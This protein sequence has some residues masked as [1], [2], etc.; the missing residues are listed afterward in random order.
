MANSGKFGGINIES[1]S[2]HSDNN[3]FSVD[4]QGKFIAQDAEITGKIVSDEGTIGGIIIE[5]NSIRTSNDLF[6]LTEEGLLTAQ[7]ADITGKITSDEGLIGGV[8]ISENSIHSANDKFIVTDAGALTAT[9]ADITGKITANEG[10]IGGNTIAANGITGLK[11]SIID[12]VIEAEDATITG[13]TR[14]ALAGKRAELSGTDNNFRLYDASES[15]L[16]D[17]DDDSAFTDATYELPETGILPR[18]KNFLRLKPG[19]SGTIGLYAVM[20]PGI[21]VGKS[22]TDAGGFSSISP[23]E[24]A[25]TGK[26]NA[27]VLYNESGE[28]TI[29]AG[30]VIIDGRIHVID[31]GTLK[32]TIDFESDVRMGGGDFWRMRWVNGSLVSA[33]NLGP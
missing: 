17:L 8:V 14:T 25:T 22:W 27:K 33:V 26:V 16:L 19:S 11:F 23:K 32:P 13:T 18:P 15:V 28:L 5:S 3:L 21:S 4:D 6:S 31:G 20:G 7:N 30:S 2:I 10:T 12:G 24:I 29:T 1:N 9:D